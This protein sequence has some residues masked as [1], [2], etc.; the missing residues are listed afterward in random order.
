MPFGS[1]IVWKCLIGQESLLRVADINH[2]QFPNSSFFG[3][4]KPFGKPVLAIRN[5]DIAKRIMV[6]NFDHFVDRNFFDANPESNKYVNMMLLILKGEL[7]KAT[8]NF[9]TPMFTASKLKSIQPL[10]HDCSKS[11]TS[12]MDGFVNN[13]GGK[14]NI[15]QYF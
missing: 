3:F 1:W 15:W 7:W 14:K 12:Y 9:M 4:Y 13:E 10:L 6:K 11:L 8:R 5:L 2:D